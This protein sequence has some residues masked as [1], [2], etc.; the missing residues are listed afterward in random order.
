MTKFIT[1]PSGQQGDVMIIYCAEV[2]SSTAPSYYLRA[3]V[4]GVLASPGDVQIQLQT[5][6]NNMCVT[7][8]RLNVSAGSP[9]IKIQWAP[10]D[11]RTEAYHR[12]ML[13]IVNTH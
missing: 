9:A 5:P 13:V 4:G 10:V 6:V 8:Y 1:I 7:F 2:A 11:G 3:L 12:S